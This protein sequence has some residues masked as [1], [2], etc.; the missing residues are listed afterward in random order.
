MIPESMLKGAVLVAFNGLSRGTM[1]DIVIPPFEVHGVT[2]DTSEGPAFLAPWV[3]QAGETYFQFVGLPEKR[4]LNLVFCLGGSVE[5]QEKQIA[6]IS[7]WISGMC[8]SVAD[9]A[10]ER[11][12]T[13]YRLLRNEETGALRTLI[14]R[15]YRNADFPCMEHPEMLLGQPLGNYHC[16]HCGEMQVAGMPHLPREFDGAP[17]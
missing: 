12:H 6:D 4:C 1:D 8:D 2:L 9:T 3:Y 13:A 11:Y 7:L 15:I 10:S 14:Y 16:G 17:A 5:L